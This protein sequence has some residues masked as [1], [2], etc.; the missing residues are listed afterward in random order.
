[1]GEGGFVNLKFMVQVESTV[2][3]KAKALPFQKMRAATANKTKKSH[4]VDG[5][6]NHTK[7]TLKYPAAIFSYVVIPLT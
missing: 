5:R 4:E 7:R 3:L 2:I 6:L 1:M